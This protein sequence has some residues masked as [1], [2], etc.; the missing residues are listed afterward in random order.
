MIETIE[1]LCAA[2]YAVSVDQT[3]YHFHDESGTHLGAI[4]FGAETEMLR[5][6]VEETFAA[7]ALS[8]DTGELQF[9]KVVAPFRSAIWHGRVAPD[10]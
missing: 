4:Q 5:I 1:M 2:F 7:R 9:H 10:A 3:T 6:L 8:I